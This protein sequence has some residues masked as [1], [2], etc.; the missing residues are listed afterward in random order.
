[1]AALT[2]PFLRL[3]PQLVQQVHD[4]CRSRSGMKHLELMVSKHVGGYL[5]PQGLAPL[6]PAGN[7]L[8]A[9]PAA[10]AVAFQIH[11]AAERGADETEREYGLA[12]IGTLKLEEVGMVP[13]GLDEGAQPHGIR[14]QLGCDPGDA[15]GHLQVQRNE[16]EPVDVFP[17][18]ETGV[19]FVRVGI[20]RLGEETL[21]LGRAQCAL[22]DEN[23]FVHD[24]DFF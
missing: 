5:V 4:C 18:V 22:P 9:L 2:Y 12:T 7:R 3:S 16:V 13:D 21:L 23:I 15:V 8:V 10:V 6:E 19:E 24:T 14:G 17:I 1:M 11:P 20:E